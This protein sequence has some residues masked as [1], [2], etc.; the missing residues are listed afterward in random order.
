MLSELEKVIQQRS[1]NWSV[2]HS[3]GLAKAQEQILEF[4]RLGLAQIADEIFRSI[5]REF[6]R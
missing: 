3:S 1:N 2:E 6:S 5:S 4:R